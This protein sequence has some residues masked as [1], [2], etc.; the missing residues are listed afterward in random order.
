MPTYETGKNTVQVLY[1]V[2]Q[3]GRI[4]VVFGILYVHPMFSKSKHVT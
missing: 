2:S 1:L 4:I 3:D